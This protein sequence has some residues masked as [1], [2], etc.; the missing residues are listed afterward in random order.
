MIVYTPTDRMLIGWVTKVLK[1]KLDIPLQSNESGN[2]EKQM[3]D[4]AIAKSPNIL[5]DDSSD[6][7]TGPSTGGH[8]MQFLDEETKQRNIPLVY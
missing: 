6:T 4:L 3:E 8:A 7:N 2:T 5:F 1:T